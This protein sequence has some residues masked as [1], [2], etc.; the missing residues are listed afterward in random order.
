MRGKI[1]VFCIALLLAFSIMPMMVHASSA[2]AESAVSSVNDE[3]VSDVQIL[4]Q[5]ETQSA[6]SSDSSDS[7]A[8][9][10]SG[11]LIP[12]LIQVCI[13]IIGCELVAVCVIIVIK[14][15]RTIK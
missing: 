9:T 6:A 7:A 8:A 4:L 14:K 10:G 5:D 1:T 15:K 2:Q 13:V 3:D 11:S 12:M